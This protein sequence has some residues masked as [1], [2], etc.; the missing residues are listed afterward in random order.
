MI[1][2][3]A[4][5]AE[6]RVVHRTKTVTR[7]GTMETGKLLHQGH[8]GRTPPFKQD[9]GGEGVLFRHEAMNP[10]CIIQDC[11][12]DLQGG[13]HHS[14]LPGIIDG[15]TEDGQKGELPLIQGLAGVLGTD[16]YAGTE[17]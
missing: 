3:S 17:G 14:N 10:S 16:T 11:G 9:V 5:G 6:H 2:E 13:D 8:P 12:G 4:I 7:E 15:I 1:Q